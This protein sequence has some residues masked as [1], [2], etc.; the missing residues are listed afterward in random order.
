[1][2]HNASIMP[3]LQNLF[4]RFRSNRMAYKYFHKNIFNLLILL[5]L[6]DWKCFGKLYGNESLQGVVYMDMQGSNIKKLLDLL[7]ISS[8]TLAKAMNVDASY[9]SR[10]VR[11]QRL[12]KFTSD[13]LTKL[14]EYFLDKIMRTDNT[15]WLKRQMESDGLLF[16]YD[17]S[18]A[19]LNALKLWLSHDGGD[20][21][22]SLNLQAANQKSTE[23]IANQQV[24]TGNLEI[25]LFFEKTLSS[26][27]D[28]FTIDIHLSNED[29]GILLHESISRMLM[30]AMSVR[31]YR[32]R[33]VVTMSSGVMA[34]SRL[35]I[36]YMQ[37]MIEG[38]LNVAVVH[39]TAQVIT[40]Q[41]TFIF[42]DTL[43]FLVSETPKTIA[44]PIGMATHETSFVKE[45]KK[46]FDR[47][48]N[49]SQPLL[50][51]YD[52]NLARNVIEIMYHEFAMP[53]DLDIIKD[54]L[55]PV[56]IA[57]YEYS[58][59]LNVIGHTGEQ[60]DWRMN[61]FHR[62]KAGIHENLNNGCSGTIDK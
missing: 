50:Q 39:G 47:A 25:A 42:G 54:N 8:A 48:Y 38:Y 20:V 31:N 12:L 13:N 58:R 15:D 30:E 27:P 1:M 14:S 57:D 18:G 17:S 37:S 11:G 52:D 29:I 34:M 56:Y 22:K 21:S 24:L 6:T 59:Y 49:F 23:N 7:E 44:P 55:N 19:L 4:R 16:D 41:A 60:H 61:E 43:V 46:S 32:I 2:A 36:R 35:L 28:G 10:W 3:S 9:I 33:L 5:S 62:F 40:N 51:R 45:S 26:L 53:G